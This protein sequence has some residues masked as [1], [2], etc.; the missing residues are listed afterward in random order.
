METLAHPQFEI[1]VPSLPPGVAPCEGVPRSS[2]TTRGVTITNADG[3][4]VA[5]GICYSVDPKLVIDT[6]GLPLG[7]ERVAIHIAESLVEEDVPSV[8]M[9]SM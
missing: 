8:W 7:D 2:W 3:I 5:K 6:D 4:D 1:R 9:W